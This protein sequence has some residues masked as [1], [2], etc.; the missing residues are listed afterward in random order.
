MPALNFR[1]ACASSAKLLYTDQP[2][3]TRALNALVVIAS[4]GTAFAQTTA[5]HVKATRGAAL[6]PLVEGS[7]SPLVMVGGGTRGAAEF[8]PHLPLLVGNFR[9]IRVQTLNIARAQ[10]RLPLPKGYS[11]KVES[12]ALKRSLDRL[13]LRTPVDLVGHSFGALVALDFA[14]DHPGRIRSLTLAEPPAF[15]VV[16]TTELRATS[17]MRT[18]F[19]LCLTLQPTIEPTDDKLVR[20]LCA[21][22][23]CGI[24]PPAQTQP[25]WPDW[26]FRR[27]ALRGLSAVATHTDNV[28]RVKTFK[29]PVL[30]VTGADTVSFHRRIDGILATEFPTA[31]RL[32]LPGGHGAVASAPQQFVREFMA[33]LSRRR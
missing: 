23:N 21:L 32:E 5:R 26:E 33:F 22:G 12:G 6:E 20:F 1:V 30:I 27:S 31:E 18:M 10:D 17:D 15:W 7:G 19:E 13:R 14:L 25:G 4:L 16:P 2:M 8:A 9:V 11:V 29:G 24:K 28:N 3:S